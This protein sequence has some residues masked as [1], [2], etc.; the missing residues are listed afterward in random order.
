MEAEGGGKVRAEA[1]L[2]KITQPPLIKGLL[3]SPM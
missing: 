2:I 3:H 1:S